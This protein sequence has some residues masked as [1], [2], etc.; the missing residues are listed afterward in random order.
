MHQVFK[1]FLQFLI[2]MLTP[3]IYFTFFS[4]TSFAC[5]NASL[6]IFGARSLTSSY[7]KELV[8]TVFPQNNI[9]GWN[10]M[11]CTDQKSASGLA[12]TGDFESIM[13]A[14]NADKSFSNGSG[15]VP[16]AAWSDTDT[17]S[18]KTLLET[19]GD[20]AYQLG[21]AVG[22]PWI[23]ILTQMRYEDP[24]SVCGANNFWGN[25]CDPSHAYAGGATIQGK[26]LGEGFVQYGQTL[27]NGNHDQALGISDPKTYLEKIGP[28]WVQ[29]DPNGPGYGSI[30]AM[31]SSVDALTAYV[32][33]S[34][35]Q[36]IIGSFTNYN[37]IDYGGT[38]SGGTST[39][40]SADSSSGGGDCN[41]TKYNYSDDELRRL[42]AI[43]AS[44]NGGTIEAL[45]NEMSLMANLFESGRGS[46][47]SSVL[48]YVINGGWFGS[49]KGSISGDSASD[50]Q[51]EAAKDVFNNGN[52]TLPPEVDEHDCIDCG[53]YGFDITSIEVNG[54][55]IT[56]SAGLLNS[57]N[58]IKNET[59]LHN[60][61][62]ATYTFYT[63]A[64][65]DSPVN[66]DPMGYTG[67]SIS[68][69]PNGTCTTYE[70]DY[71]QYTQQTGYTCGPTS[72]A[73]LATVASG[74]DVSE[75]DV[76]SIVGSDRAYA[77]TVGSGMVSLD[78][79]VGEKYGFDV[80]QIDVSEGN[81][82]DVISKMKEYLNKGY[83]IHYSGCGGQISSGCHYVGIFK[84]D[85][86][87]A[88]L[89]DSS[90]RGNREVNIDEFVGSAYHGDAFSAIKVG[91]SNGKCSDLCQTDSGTSGNGNV[92]KA[93]EDI[94]EL[95][96]KN[97][98]TYTW[99]GGHSGDA[100]TFDS[101]LNGA[102]INVDCTGFAS[103]VMYKAFGQMTSF[104]S[105][106]IFNDP[107]YEEVSR[108]DVRPGDVFAYEAPSGHGGIV[109]E[110][111]NGEVT[112]IAETNKGSGE[113]VKNPPNTNIGYSGADDFSVQ[114][115][116]GPNG[117]FFRWKGN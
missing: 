103:L 37:G 105:S 76:I 90:S 3:I 53:S 117:H 113:G 114:N 107:L 55:T 35:G 111:S 59:V 70:G 100:G 11:E 74:Q 54:N 2:L 17:G 63:W 91:G 19:Y 62:S 21:R 69:D 32:E 110:V 56:D 30:D 67:D 109:I 24:Q 102:P 18:M 75:A 83:M 94:I 23:A 13:K 40:T 47:Y 26:N 95:A 27:T 12:G 87:Q 79:K 29:G 85:G 52:R 89:A 73:M 42:A 51:F 33:S 58:Y 14:K 44:E 31:K 78:Q 38:T 1:R 82:S 4:D 77:N 34:E 86:D 61:Y 15:D 97:G 116:N 65:P 106:S 92:L 25:G 99:G 104:S 72:M 45:K 48:D 22:A 43:A 50:E 84:L 115:M 5:S 6:D 57:D 71:P 49:S 46:G 108:S 9:N 68:C 41:F 88:L 96:N 101:M 66:S 16:S 10:P 64:D 93:V 8:E 39:S 81:T 28:T 7:S 60:R 112:K 80:E 36:S 98:S 20:L